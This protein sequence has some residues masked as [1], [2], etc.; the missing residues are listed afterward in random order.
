VAR[1]VGS[2]AKSMVGVS[3]VTVEYLG[4]KNSVAG[5]MVDVLRAFPAFC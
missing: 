1:A 5:D 2:A 3:I 4:G